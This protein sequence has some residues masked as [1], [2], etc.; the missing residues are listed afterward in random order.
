MLS[1]IRDSEDNYVLK[2]ATVRDNMGVS[3]SASQVT[4]SSGSKIPDK[5]VKHSPPILDAKLR[6]SHEVGK[7][8][9][10]RSADIRCTLT[11]EV[12]IGGI[13]AFVLFNSRAETDA[14][15]P[16]FIRACHIPL[17]ELP[18]PL[19]LQMG[20]K[21]SRS[22]VYYGTNVDVT[23][24]GVKNSHYFDIVNIDRYDAVLGA[25]WLN[26]HGT[27]LNFTNHTI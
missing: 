2:L 15:S 20:T 5:I 26:M 7:Y 12:K 21:G 9:A 8:P 25:P 6:L 27:I 19:V 13:D 16:D 3:N 11:A 14:L 4:D 18:N 23:I 24:H 1:F 10:D 17:L 22:C